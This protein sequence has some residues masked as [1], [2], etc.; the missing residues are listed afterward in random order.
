MT[1]FLRDLNYKYGKKRKKVEHSE[2]MSLLGKQSFP[3]NLQFTGHSVMYLHLQYRGDQ[4][5]PSLRNLI[6]PSGSISVR[7]E[8][9]EKQIESF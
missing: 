3:R 7:V 6:V 8:W 1:T 2:V 5:Q 9:R 4:R